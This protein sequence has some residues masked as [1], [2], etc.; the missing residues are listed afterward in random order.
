[1]PN[2]SA[3]SST[4][5]AGSSAT[6]GTHRATRR[7]CR[8]PSR[9]S[10]RPSTHATTPA[11]RRPLRGHTRDLSATGLSLILPAVRIG[12]RYL[13]G[14]GRPVQITLEL[15]AGAIQLRAIPVRYERLGDEE[16]GERGYL[17]GAHIMEM[18][19]ED[20]TRFGDYVRGLAK[21]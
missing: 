2:V 20:M 13:T 16:G 21:G 19:A 7:G 11:V 9:T 15:P 17:V 6:A 1:M 10:R 5:S 12:D 18:D 14:E 4:T 8:H 3:H